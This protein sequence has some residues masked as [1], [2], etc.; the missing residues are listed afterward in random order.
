MSKSPRPD[1]DGYAVEVSLLRFKPLTLTL[2]AACLV[3]LVALLGWLGFGDVRQIAASQ[4]L[5]NH[6]AN[7]QP[8]EAPAAIPNSATSQAAPQT[9]RAD[10]APSPKEEA[11]ARASA[12]PE[13]SP[14]GFAETPAP[15]NA[16]APAPSNAAADAPAATANAPAGG[17]Y[18]V[19][20]GSFNTAS[21]ANERVSALRAAGFEARTA[22]VELARRGTW[23]RVYSGRFASREEAS[24]HDRKLRASGAVG[25]TLVTPLQD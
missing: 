8:R 9:S 4:P 15:S 19:Q 14:S 11:L 3:T 21:E 10:A 12:A 18:A 23:Y 20:A 5:K 25:D 17:G 2:T 16:Q 22:A 13:P 7:Q 6:A 1:G 24:R